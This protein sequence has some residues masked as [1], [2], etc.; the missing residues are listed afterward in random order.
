MTTLCSVQARLMFNVRRAIMAFETI[1]ES[2]VMNMNITELPIIG[3]DAA[4]ILQ[5]VSSYLIAAMMSHCLVSSQDH[6]KF[7]NDQ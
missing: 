2:T 1:L 6:S 4:L 5:R 3:D 7:F